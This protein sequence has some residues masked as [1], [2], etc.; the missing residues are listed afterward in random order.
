MSGDLPPLF[1]F[2]RTAFAPPAE[3]AAFRECAPVTRVQMADGAT[4]W[5]VTRHDLVRQVLA[6]PRLS[7]NPLTPGY[8]A[9]T[10]GRV[11]LLKSEI[12][13]TFIRMDPPQHTVVR[14]MFTREFTFARINEMKPRIETV[15][16]QLLDAL[17]ERGA[18]ADF[19]GDF[20]VPF[21]TTVTSGFLGIPEED[22]LFFQER[23]RTRVAL[24][25]EPGAPIEA[26]RQMRARIEAILIQRLEEPADRADLIG[27]MLAD[28]VVPGTMTLDEAAAT[29]E[30]FMMAGH[31][32]TANMLTLG[33]LSM[34]MD[35]RGL[36]ALSENENAVRNAVEEMLRFHSIVQFNG[37]RAAF[38]DAEIGGITIRKGDGVIA[39]INAANRD[40][41]MFP[42]P[43]RFDPARDAKGHLAFSF[44]PHQCLG[45]GL[46]RLEMFVAF[47]ELARRMPD[48]RLAVGVDELVF[49]SGSLVHGVDKLPIAW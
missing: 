37:L 6:D 39:L 47:T 36:G 4:A 43:D 9:V 13:Q 34:L 41:V 35:P 33:L 27:R 11:K 42:D 7:T 25:L 18:P 30:L 8:P 46:A 19:F 23:S 48:M 24:D 10:L 22:H 5:L 3:Y 15:V 49:R 26:A 44:G 16:G 28:Y 32:T 12:P 20:A 40:P 29:L 2:E 38:E 1:P 45:Q 17:E 14:R 31:E 21:P